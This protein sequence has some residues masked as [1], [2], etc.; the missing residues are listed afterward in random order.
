MIKKILVFK[1]L[2]TLLFFP[3]AA[4]SAV[5]WNVAA[6]IWTGT[7]IVVTGLTMAAAAPI[8]VSGALAVGAVAGVLG[9]YWDDASPPTL[10]SGSTASRGLSVVLDPNTPLVAPSGWTEAN[11]NSIASN[12]NLEPSPPQITEE[13]VGYG[14][15]KIEGTTYQTNDWS[16]IY[17]QML[18][19]LSLEMGSWTVGVTDANAR[20]NNE[21]HVFEY[22]RITSTVE[23]R[24]AFRDVQFY[25]SADSVNTFKSPA[26]PSGY[27]PT[28]NQNV[29]TCNLTDEAQVQKPADDVCE[30]RVKTGKFTKMR[31]DPDCNNT[32]MTGIG[33]TQVIATT[34]EK[35]IY[36][37]TSASND[38]SVYEKFYNA[39]TNKT[40]TNIASVAASGTVNYLQT[41]SA[42]GNQVGVNPGVIDAS[43]GNDGSGSGSTE[44]AATDGKL[45]EI[46]AN[47]TISDKST[48]DNP[49]TGNG[50]AD[51]FNPLKSFSVTAQSGQC[52]TTDL[53][54]FDQ[55]YSL[56]LHCTIFN[57][58]KPTIQSASTLA[59]LIAALFIV[60]S[61]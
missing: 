11:P 46:F 6:Y 7:A 35:A 10:S 50:F 56:D 60:L 23:V 38:V 58:H 55:T 34:P 21:T 42:L 43:N 41:V 18:D 2:F 9:I 20:F 17:T 31:N 53:E 22:D 44:G 40:T 37:V 8:V 24:E 12:A 61:A 26:C 54:L 57:E 25:S 39:T 59:Y 14:Y 27:T 49:D 51:F 4:L 52:P 33:S 19:L 5:Y 1:F 30:V 15:F 16:E 13:R 48:S 29:Q 36:L 28:Y 45:D 32:A 47:G 3:V